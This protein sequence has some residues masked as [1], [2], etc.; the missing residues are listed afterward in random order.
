MVTCRC[1]QMIVALSVISC[2]T[3]MGIEWDGEVPRGLAA[4][5]RRISKRFADSLA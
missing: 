1:G 2:A 4:D 3:R 5:A